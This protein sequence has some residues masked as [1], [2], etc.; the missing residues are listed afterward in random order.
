MCYVIPLC[1]YMAYKTVILVRIGTCLQ[2][3]QRFATNIRIKALCI[4]CSSRRTWFQATRINCYWSRN[5]KR[6]SWFGCST[7][8]MISR[9][10][11]TPVFYSILKI[12]FLIPINIFLYTKKS[13]NFF[14]SFRM[15]IWDGLS[16]WS[17]Y[18]LFLFSSS[19]DFWWIFSNL[20]P[21]WYFGT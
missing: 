9:H 12:L 6:S 21:F 2:G 16:L 15:Q 8:I 1:E 18:Q 3:S 19:S 17:T 11:P 4:W 20:G 10:P 5:R 7:N 13:L 14:D